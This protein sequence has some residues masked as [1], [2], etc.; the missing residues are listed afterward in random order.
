MVPD[1][2]VGEV[3]RGVSPPGD[4]ADGGHGTQTSALQDMGVP[5]NWS[6]VGDDGYRGYRV[7]YPLPQEHDRAIHC[8]LSYHGLVFGGGAESRNA[9]IQVMVGTDHLGYHWDQDGAGSHRGG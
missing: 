4:T 8:D 7:I 5:T 1:P 9:P 3:P 6:G 2:P